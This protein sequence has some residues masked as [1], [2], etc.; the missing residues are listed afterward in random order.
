MPVTVAALAI[1][2][3]KG[4]RLMAA[5][6]LEIGPTGASG[7]RAF[8]VVEDGDQRLVA[9]ARNPELV[10]VTARWDPAGGVLALGFPGG[11]E[12]VASVGAA[13]EGGE[14]VATELYDGR[15]VGGRLVER[16]P[17]CEA[18]SD[19]L[20][21]RVRLMRLDPGVTGADDFPVT[22]MSTASL[23]A[24]GAALGGG[25]PDARRFRMTVTVGGLDAW[26]EHGWAGRE[27]RLGPEVRLRVVD[28]VPRC[29]VTTS[30]PEDG[31]RDVPVLHALARLRGKDDVA[32]G[33]WCQVVAPGRVR[34]GDTVSVDA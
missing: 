21:R 8:V 10:Q 32:F 20:G 11:V 29:V 13:A 25:E 17:L 1:A 7:D 6:E 30:D 15:R 12:A 3:V 9:T 27:V 23:A 26:E 14:E 33:V 24:V 2:P 34:R 28:S 22:L 5:A 18:L 31:A 16:G 19:H 4:M